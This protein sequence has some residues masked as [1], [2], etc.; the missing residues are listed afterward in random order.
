[1]I[2]FFF[3]VQTINQKLREGT[4]KISTTT[5][6][7]ILKLLFQYDKHID[8]NFERPESSVEYKNVFRIIG[9][10]GIEKYREFEKNYAAHYPITDLDKE[11]VLA[12][13]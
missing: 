2:N 5:V 11:K 3:R 4:K 8:I 13:L 12:I 1:M 7:K 9:T 6:I 10:N